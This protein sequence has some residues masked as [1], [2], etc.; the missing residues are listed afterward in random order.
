VLD[1][2]PA[3]AHGVWHLI[4]AYIASRTRSYFQRLIRFSL[5]ANSWMQVVE[6]HNAILENDRKPLSYIDS[7]VYLVADVIGALSHPIIKST[8]WEVVVVSMPVHPSPPPIP[9]HRRQVLDQA[10]PN[11]QPARL[12]RHEKVFQVTHWL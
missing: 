7:E 6:S 10:S 2:L 3:H 12:G 4:V 11:T 5:P 1:G 8:G 9:A